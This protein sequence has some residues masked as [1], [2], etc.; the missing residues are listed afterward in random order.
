VVEHDL[1]KVG[2][3]GSNPF[4][5]SRNFRMAEFN[6]GPRTSRAFRFGNSDIPSIVPFRPGNRHAS[7]PPIARGELSHTRPSVAL[8][9]GGLLRFAM[10]G[11][12][13]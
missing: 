2:V 12:C 3:E 4:A 11:A 10:S 1:A 5:R 6:E 7:A 9:L 13:H 8:G